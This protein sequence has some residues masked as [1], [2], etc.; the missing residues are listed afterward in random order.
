[1]AQK[2]P[3]LFATWDHG[4][5]SISGL[6]GANLEHALTR[7]VQ[8]W[9]FQ[10][11]AYRSVIAPPLPGAIQESTTKHAVVGLTATPTHLVHR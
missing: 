4:T 10:Q 11:A 5:L 7:I 6:T 1:M 9:T 2:K 8:Q 3:F